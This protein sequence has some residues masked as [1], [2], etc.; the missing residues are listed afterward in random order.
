MGRSFVKYAAVAALA[1]GMVFAQTPAGTSQSETGTAKQGRHG[2]MRRH[3]G[4]VTQALNLTDSQK[5]Q[6]RAIFQ[7]ARESSQPLRRQLKQNREALQAAAKANTGDAEIQR[8]ANE[9]GSLLA[10]LV[11]IR[12]EASAKFYQL[13]TPEQ[14]A[15]ADQLRGQ[16]RQQRHS[17]ERRN[18]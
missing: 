11:T 3:L 16:F 4:R 5:Q 14:R 10:Q 1:T 8:L 13:L 7:Q 17:A 15:K 18:G 6:S 2:F 9:Q 12:T